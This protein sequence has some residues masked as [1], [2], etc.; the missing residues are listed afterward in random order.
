[1]EFS[2]FVSSRGRS[3]V[4]SA[5]LLT[6]DLTEAEDLVQVALMRVLARWED[7]EHPVAYTQRTLVRLFLDS[8]RRERRDPMSNAIVLDEGLSI[9]EDSAVD[10]IGL[11]DA[12]WHGVAGL[13]P[14]ERAVVVLRYYEDLDDCEIASIL[15]VRPSSVRASASRAV[16]RLRRTHLSELQEN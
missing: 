16:A 11:S 15:R 8:T 4:Q 14:R 7:V 5:Y 13:P 12:L 3:L 2:A 6:N 9:S 1:M 10:R